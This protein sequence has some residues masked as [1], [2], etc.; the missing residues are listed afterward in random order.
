MET[1]ALKLEDPVECKGVI[2]R[3]RVSQYSLTY[4]SPSNFGVL[5]INFRVQLRKL[6]RKSCP[7]C[8]H[9]GWI[10]DLLDEID[11]EENYI[12]GIESAEDQKLYTIVPVYSYSDSMMMGHPELDYLEL[13]EVKDD[14]KG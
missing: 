4:K 8:E 2:F 6:K 5:S 13:Q 3:A 9:C 7:G 14:E 1:K 11:M 12:Q 10:Y